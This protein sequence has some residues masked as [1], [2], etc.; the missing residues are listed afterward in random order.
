MTSRKVRWVSIVVVCLAGLYVLCRKSPFAATGSML[1]PMS[2][3]IHQTFTVESNQ[4]YQLT[5]PS[6]Q[7][8]PA[9][10]LRGHWT[11]EG[12]SANIKG[13]TDDTLVS[14]TLTGPNSETL[15]RQDHPMSG[16]FAI[17]CLGGEYSM[18]FNN[19]GILRSSNRMV[20]VDGT[21][22]PD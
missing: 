8:E 9:R 21:Y 17:R 5:L 13:A 1:S 11:V 18:T 2:V 16:N 20:T 12:K 4:Q 22:Q 3:P 15:E 14:F 7:L 10:W 19:T 6:P